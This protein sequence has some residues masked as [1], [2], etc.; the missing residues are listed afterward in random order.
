LHTDPGFD[1][2]SKVAGET[3]FVLDFRGLEDAVMQ[4]ASETAQSLAAEIAARRRVRFD[5]G[6]PSYST[7]GIMDPDL[8][9]KLRMIAAETGV[10]SMEL[11]S[12]AGHDAAV[13]AS[14]GVPTGMIF[15]RNANGSHNPDEA[16]AIEDFGLAAGL[17]AEAIARDAV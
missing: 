15:I 7:P 17:L 1:G 16:M 12:G 8:R 10:A 9:S 11:A 14:Y 3:R 6:A 5:L 13:F 4:R 2:P